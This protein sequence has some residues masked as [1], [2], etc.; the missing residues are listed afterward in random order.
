VPRH[1]EATGGGE[2]PQELHFS[3]QSL[4]EES[5]ENIPMFFTIR[6]KPGDQG[7]RRILPPRPI[8][9]RGN[10]KRPHSLF[11]KTSVRNGVESV[12]SLGP[13]SPTDNG[14]RGQPCEFVT[15]LPF[16]RGACRS[17]T[18]LV[19]RREKS[20]SPKLSP[21]VPLTCLSCYTLLTGGT[22]LIGRHPLH[23]FSPS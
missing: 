14:K 15:N 22:G 6:F 17:I 4:C 21:S 7:S 13:P 18:R 12:S 16:L 11:L 1:G 10:Q 5:I 19:D 3:A 9:G 23:D 8:S 20:I 2:G